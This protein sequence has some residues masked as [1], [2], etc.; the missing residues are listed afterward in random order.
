[1]KGGSPDLE[2]KTAIVV[3]CGGIGCEAAGGLASLGA[4]VVIAGRDR[5]KGE[6]A[7]EKILREHGGAAV[8]FEPLDMFAP[9]SI[10]AFADRVSAS[11]D[12]VDIILC[13][14]GVMMPD[15]VELTTAG[16][17]RQ[18][19]VNYLGYYELVGRL[20]PLLMKSHCRR[21]VTV[22]SI[23]NRPIRFDLADAT[24]S[25][26]RH[27]ASISYAL[28]KLC[29]LMYAIEL[30][31]RFP[32]VTAC[33]VHPGLARTELFDRSGRFIMR[34]LRAIFFVLPFVRQSARAAAKP[35]L[36]AATSPEAK[37]GE[38]YGPMFTIMGPPRRALIPL[39]AGSSRLR[40]ELWMMSEELTGVG[41]G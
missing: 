2:G 13:V 24:V 7:A 25:G 27:D 26:R 8:S 16:V 30:S 38:Y 31:A 40:G 5:V 22:S 17:E 14:A 39:R 10:R 15:D 18:F 1:M 6:A 32:G 4:S 19:A 35:L 3:G 41:Y 34:L 9:D 28:S 33:C 11:H 37:G 20:M 21:V 36:Y 29:C 12:R 23:A